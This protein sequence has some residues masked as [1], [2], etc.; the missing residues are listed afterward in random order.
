MHARAITTFGLAALLGSGSVQA[1]DMS[2]MMNP[3]KWFGGKK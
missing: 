1:L 3:S 2:D